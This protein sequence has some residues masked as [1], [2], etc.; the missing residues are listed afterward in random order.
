MFEFQGDIE[1]REKPVAGEAFKIGD[2]C[3]SETVSHARLLSLA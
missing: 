3:F 1:C 2:L